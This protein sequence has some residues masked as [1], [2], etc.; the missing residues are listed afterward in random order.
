MIRAAARLAA[1]DVG[2]MMTSMILLIELTT[3]FFPH[4]IFKFRDVRADELDYIER[5]VRDQRREI[6]RERNLRG[7]VGGVRVE[8]R[9]VRAATANDRKVVA[10]STGDLR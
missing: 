4:V 3:K 1:S 2:W 5:F 7:F 10:F 9:R 6:H 8:K